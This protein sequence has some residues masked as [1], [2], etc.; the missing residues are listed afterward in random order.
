M[1]RLPLAKT[2]GRIQDLVGRAMAAYEN[3]RAPNRAE[4]VMVPLREAFDLLITIRGRYK[5]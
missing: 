2:L 4:A 1:K 5:P 3:D